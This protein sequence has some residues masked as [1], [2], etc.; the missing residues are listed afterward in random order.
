[1]P[2]FT[3]TAPLLGL[4]LTGGRSIRMGQDKSLLVYHAKP[5][6][7]HLTELLRPVCETVYWSVNAD[8]ACALTDPMQPFLVDD[9]PDAGPLSGI[10][11]AMMHRPDA[12]WLVVPCDLPHLSGATL[13]ALVAGRN[14]AA[15]ATAFWNADRT[16]PASLV[17]L[18]EP[19]SLA[20]LVH[21]L[22][23]GPRS[24]RQWLMANGVQLIDSP[25]AADWLNVNTPADCPK[26]L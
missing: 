15:C 1:M 13:A 26:N 17:G 5:Q 11:S 24:P 8:Q 18:W 7:E 20:L 14:P 12:A 4:V 23:T 2:S 19:G 9:L 6:R 3:D 21:Q 10:V 16:G 22:A 25:H